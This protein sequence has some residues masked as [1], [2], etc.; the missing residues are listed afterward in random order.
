MKSISGFYSRRKARIEKVLSKLETMS[1]QELCSCVYDSIEA[2]LMNT[3]ATKNYNTTLH[4]D[5]QQLRTLSMLAAGL[6]GKL[7]AAAFRCMVFDYR[8]FSGGLPDLLLARAY[9]S[10]ISTGIEFVDLGDWIGESFS[11]EAKM[12]QEMRKGF[13]ILSDRDEE[14][15]GCSKVGDSGTSRGKNRSN[16]QASR[17]GEK[18]K[19]SL[20]DLPGKLFLIHNDRPV[21][22]QC[23]FVEVKSQNDRLDGRQEDWL[24]VLDRFGNARV[25]KFVASKQRHKRQKVESHKSAG[26]NH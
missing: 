9:F 8:H 4:R 23:M 22:V 18:V 2:R 3:N 10:D 5:M 7:L 26:T 6:G 14:F 24:N 11:R 20:P 1:P 21:S 12:E 16:M 13:Q 15:L 17:N 19:L 25:C